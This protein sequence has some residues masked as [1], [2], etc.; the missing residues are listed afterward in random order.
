MF[1]I[2]VIM[3]CI[4]SC[5]FIFLFFSLNIICGY[6]KFLLILYDGDNIFYSEL[7]Q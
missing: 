6:Y 4:L 1:Y 5:S 3:L 7:L 2:A